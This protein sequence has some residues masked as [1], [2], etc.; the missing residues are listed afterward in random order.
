[1]SK[2]YVANLPGGV[3]Y[4]ILRSLFG[5]VGRLNHVKIFVDTNGYSNGSAFVEYVHYH[6]AENAIL[7]LH[8][9]ILNQNRIRVCYFTSRWDHLVKLRAEAV[10]SIR[11]RSI[12]V[13]SIDVQ[14]EYG[15]L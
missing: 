14:G 4:Q 8:R 11:S 9:T 12:Q 13:N 6:D 10:E 2:L 3:N 7:S 5:R 15:Q 1:M